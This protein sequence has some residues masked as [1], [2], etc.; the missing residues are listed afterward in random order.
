[1]VACLLAS[2]KSSALA[3]PDNVAFVSSFSQSPWTYDN[4]QAVSVV[5]PG[6]SSMSPV[7]QPCVASN[8]KSSLATL[9]KSAHVPPRAVTA[10]DVQAPSS[11][12]YIDREP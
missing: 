5:C 11:P 10:D 2:H 6:L 7:L 4:A 12:K 9:L 3:V 1:M 8:G